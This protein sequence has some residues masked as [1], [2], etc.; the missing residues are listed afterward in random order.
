MGGGEGWEGVALGML[1]T[2]THIRAGAEIDFTVGRVRH[3]GIHPTHLF[4]TH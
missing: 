4:E 2:H 3:S 1:E